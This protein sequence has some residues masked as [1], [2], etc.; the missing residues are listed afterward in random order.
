MA[1]AI[2]CL[3]TKRRLAVMNDDVKLQYSI[4][5][6][7]LEIHVEACLLCGSVPA[8][9]RADKTIFYSYYK[10][11]IRG[12]TLREAFSGAESVT[13]S[14]KCELPFSISVGIC[15]TCH[16][17]WEALN[18]KRQE[19]REKYEEWE[20]K[21]KQI[22]SEQFKELAAKKRK[23]DFDW[24][25]KYIVPISVIAMLASLVCFISGHY[26]IGAI[27]VVPSLFG[28]E[29]L[30]VMAT[31]KREAWANRV[32]DVHNLSKTL[33]ITYK[34]EKTEAEH[35]AEAL[36]DPPPSDEPEAGPDFSSRVKELILKRVASLGKKNLLPP[37][38]AQ[39]TQSEL[40]FWHKDSDGLPYR[41]ED[42][43]ISILDLS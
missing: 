13:E 40:G 1:E 38:F 11:R 23:E 8:N 36:S 10:F 28:V 27:L 20:N 39:A 19:W 37:V 33:N 17:Q 25:V 24:G 32:P 9:H 2:L 26:I 21:K 30:V 7:E 14:S 4:P 31:K 41:L 35:R 3:L 43:F 15:T 34:K 5:A 18:Q 22:L 29:Y 16:D 6:S 42:T 12:A